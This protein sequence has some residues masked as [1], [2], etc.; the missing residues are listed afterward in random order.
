MVDR[1]V[2]WKYDPNPFGLVAFPDKWRICPDQ[3][4]FEQQ[5]LSE[6]FLTRSP[7]G[8]PGSERRFCAL[9]EICRDNAFGWLFPSLPLAM[10]AGTIWQAMRDLSAI[11]PP[12]GRFSGQVKADVE[13]VDAGRGRAPD[14]RNHGAQGYRR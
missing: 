12:R 6:Y 7:A 14:P 2:L 13:P 3:T 1:R 5:G 4:I 8:A 10:R 11:R 9:I